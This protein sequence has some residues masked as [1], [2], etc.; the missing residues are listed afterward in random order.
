MYVGLCIWHSLLK[1]TSQIKNDILDKKKV[2]SWF[3]AETKYSALVYT[4]CLIWWKQ[5]GSKKNKWKTFSSNK[6]WFCQLNGEL[7]S[8]EG[9]LYS[10][11]IAQFYNRIY[12]TSHRYYT[13]TVKAS[14][15]ISSNI[16]FWSTFYLYRLYTLWNFETLSK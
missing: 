15:S 6:T 12:V 11:S 5:N 3:L 10:H 7:K 16:F 4:F 14:N 9:N 2:F 13:V 8:F 1:Y